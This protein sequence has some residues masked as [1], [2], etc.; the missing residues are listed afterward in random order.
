MFQWHTVWP[1]PAHTTTPKPW[2][3]CLWTQLVIVEWSFSQSA[4]WLTS[5]LWVFFLTHRFGDKMMWKKKNNNNLHP[6]SLIVW[7]V[8]W[9]STTWWPVLDQMVQQPVFRQR[10]AVLHLLW[11]HA[12][13]SPQ[14]ETAQDSEQLL[15][16]P[17]QLPGWDHRMFRCLQREEGGWAQL[18]SLQRYRVSYQVFFLPFQI[19][20]PFFLVVK[21]ILADLQGGL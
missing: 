20:F 8:H 12:A 13:G 17:Q 19:L 6:P 1:A 18:W 2:L 4:P 21:Q 7:A 15:Q 10:R 11:E 5:G 3:T 16:S 9:G 14:N